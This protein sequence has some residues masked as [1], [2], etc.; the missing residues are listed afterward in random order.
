VVSLVSRERI[1]SAVALLSIQF[2]VARIIG[3]LLAGFVFL[4]FAHKLPFSAACN[5]ALFSVGTL[6][7]ITALIRLRDVPTVTGTD[8]SMI[9]GI[10]DGI[11]HLRR[12]PDLAYLYMLMMIAAVL[13]V[14]FATLVPAYVKK[15]LVL[16]ADRYTFA[17]SCAGVGAVIGAII[18][19][20]RG[21]TRSS[22]RF[23]YIV[24]MI[25]A[26]FVTV[27]GFWAHYLVLI[28]VAFVSGM[29]FMSL[30]V[31]VKSNMMTTTPDHLRGRMSSH[32]SL[33]MH[34]SGPLGAFATGLVAERF[35]VMIAYR[36]LGVAV[37]L[38][39]LALVLAA[40]RFRA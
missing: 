21:N 23:V 9:R 39:L 15:I 3:P 26:T 19:A 18:Q 10:R 17:M 34:L 4:A 38:S 5:F 8:G 27:A 1:T 6:I 16:G 29:S 33:S 32:L 13:T 36:A 30:L 7:Y 20:S 14:S 37:L 11:G 12:R 25:S 40:R 28:V 2:Q 35:D 22:P 24:V 31:A